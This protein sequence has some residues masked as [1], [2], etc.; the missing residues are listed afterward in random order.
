MPRFDSEEVHGLRIRTNAPG[1]CPS[2][3]DV[4]RPIAEP[5]ALCWWLIDECIFRRFD[6][7]VP[8][9]EV[10]FEA[11]TRER[12]RWR[13]LLVPGF[14][15]AFSRY[16]ESTSCVIIGLD[17]PQELRGLALD[18]SFVRQARCY[19]E[20]VDAAYWQVFSADGSLLEQMRLHF[21]ASTE[22]TEKELVYFLPGGADQEPE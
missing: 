11:A 1:V 4:V 8:F 19:F 22:L 17:A 10:A 9:D 3:G 18:V 6:T 21:P 12:T 5:V 2:F 14:V 15:E 13:R 7:E 20:C 16:V